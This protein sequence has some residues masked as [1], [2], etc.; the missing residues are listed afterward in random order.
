MCLQVCVCVRV[1][2][3]FFLTVISTQQQKLRPGCASKGGE[4]KPQRPTAAYLFFSFSTPCS[5]G[6]GGKLVH[7]NEFRVQSMSHFAR[8]WK[9]SSPPWHSLRVHLPCVVQCHCYSTYY[10]GAGNWKKPSRRA[11]LFFTTRTNWIQQ[12]GLNQWERRRPTR[13]ARRRR[14]I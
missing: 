8:Q 14:V 9:C 2:F 1:Q 11:V 4:K 3:F 10:I 6:V 13:A 7:F 12:A 5:V